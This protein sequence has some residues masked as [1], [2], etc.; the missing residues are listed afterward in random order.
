MS[1]LALWTALGT[2]RFVTLSESHPRSITNT[3]IGLP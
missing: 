2:A 3:T 1:L